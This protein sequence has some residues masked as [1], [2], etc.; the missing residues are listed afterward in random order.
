M[1]VVLAGA[2]LVGNAPPEVE[3]RTG[4]PAVEFVTAQTR[5]L[6]RML[7]E[8]DTFSAAIA[9][10]PVSYATRPGLLARLRDRDVLLAFVESYGASA[11]DDPRYA[12]VIRPRLDGLTDGVR[13]AGL[14]MATGQLV[15]PTQGGQSW[16]SHM[17]VLSA[18]SGS[19]TN[20]DTTCC[21]RAG[22]R[23]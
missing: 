14:H 1:L 22:V 8:R 15:A 21:C 16:F 9:T 7:S 13:T 6:G 12:P 3:R 20:C 4:V 18:A 10:A 5:H 23:P 19:T 11:I 17:S 2:A